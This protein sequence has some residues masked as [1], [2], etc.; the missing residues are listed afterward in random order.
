MSNITLTTTVTQDAVPYFSAINGFNLMATIKA[1]Q[2]KATE[3]SPIDMIC[4]VDRFSNHH[5]EHFDLI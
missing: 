2:F 4:V 3:R 1:P 5:S